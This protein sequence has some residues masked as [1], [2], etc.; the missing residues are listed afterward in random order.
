MPKPS[1]VDD[2]GLV[3]R[4]PDALR[5]WTLCNC[6]C[7]IITTAICFS[8]HRYSMR[9][10]HLAQRCVATRHMTDNIFEM[11]TTALAHFSCVTCDSCVQKTD[12]ACAYPNVTHS[13]I[14]HV[15]EGAEWPRFIPQF[16][17][18]IFHNSVTDV[19]FMVRGIRQGCPASGFLFATAFDPIF[20]WPHGS[21]I[22]MNPTD[23]EFLQPGS[24]AYANDFADAGVSFRS[25]MP[26]LSPAVMA[27]ECIA[28]LTLIIGNAMGFNMAATYVKN[29]WIG[30]P[31]S[32]V[33]FVR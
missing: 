15:L 32:V 22:S 30:S 28:G 16:L 26:A 3:V 18:M 21:V 11:D 33:S 17:R 7:K 14:F 4:S 10:I 20:R 2:N 24:C 8:L 9:C 29:S 12:F 23:P 1:T 5:S 6:D 13:W 19:E 25:L 31:E 27:V